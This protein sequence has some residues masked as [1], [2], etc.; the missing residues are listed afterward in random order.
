M[1]AIGL[2]ASVFAKGVDENQIGLRKA[3]LTDENKVKIQ[4]YTFGTGSAGESKKIERSYENAPPLI[5][6]DITGMTPITQ[7]N[8]ACLDC[9]LPDVAESVGATPIPKS[10]TY[11]LRMHKEVSNGIAEQRYNCTQCHVPQAQTKPLVKNKFQPGFHNEK[12]KHQSN[13]LDVINQGVK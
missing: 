1:V 2:G 3:P 13:L 8:N 10:H 11:D 9:H 5:P 4:D 7:K 12:Q 6:H